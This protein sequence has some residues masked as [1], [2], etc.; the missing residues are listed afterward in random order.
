MLSGF[1]FTAPLVSVLLSFLKSKI[2]VLVLECLFLCH[3]NREPSGKLLRKYIFKKR[4]TCEQLP[5]TI[6][7]K[8]I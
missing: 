1:V 7:S 2:R 5:A 4:N 3:E 8:E 6:T